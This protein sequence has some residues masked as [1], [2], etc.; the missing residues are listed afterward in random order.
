[1][2]ERPGQPDSNGGK[3]TAAQLDIL[4]R[5]VES[6]P[7]FPALAAA[8]L[9]CTRA[10]QADAGQSTPALQRAIEL[11]CSDAPSVAVLLKTASARGGSPVA[12]IAEA[13]SGLGLAG[14]RHA[15]LTLDI[16]PDAAPSSGLDREAFWRHNQAVAVAARQ[17]AQQIDPPLDADTAFTAGLLHDL[18]KCVLDVLLPKSFRRAIELSAQNGTD[19]CE[20]ERQVIGLDHAVVGRRLAQQWRLPR[21]VAEAAW[22]HHQP[23]TVLPAAA[24]NV[25]LILAVQLADGLA[26]QAKVGDSGNAGPVALS[27]AQALDLDEADLQSVRDGLAQAVQRSAGEIDFEAPAAAQHYYRALKAAAAEMSDRNATLEAQEA[28]LAAQARA[29]EH[30][31][32]FVASLGDPSTT[33]DVMVGIAQVLARAG[34]IVPSADQPVVGYVVGQGDEQGQAVRL[35]GTH[36]HAW[37]SLGSHGQA[38]S[39]PDIPLTAS[40][41]DIAAH[42]DA[43]AQALGPWLDFATYRH[44]A[45]VCAGQWLGGVFLPPS[46]NKAP[47]TTE[48]PFSKAPCTAGGSFREF[49]GSAG[50]FTEASQASAVSDNVLEALAGAMAMALTIVQGRCRA[51]LLSE[52]LA[53]ASQVLA[54]TQEALTEARTVGAVGQMAAGAAHELNNP[55]AVISGRAQLMSERAKT[56]EERKV[57]QLMVTQAHRISDILSDLMEFAAPP[58]PQKTAFDVAQLL[59]EAAEAFSSSAH[60]QAAAA[61]V[62]IQVQADC[63]Q[64][65]ADR[66]QV[67]AVIVELMNNAATAA[68]GPPRLTLGTHEDQARD[69]VVISLADEGPGMDDQTLAAAFTPFFSLQRSGRRRGLGL[70]RARRQIES[71]GGRIWLTSQAGAGTCVYVQLPRPAGH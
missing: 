28:P 65:W 7:T 32:N 69:A 58:P 51:V 49:P 5:R 24:G 21:E 46:G 34:G 48:E 25:R 2:A 30:L 70:P 16:F 52:Q 38:V 50:G 29:F 61:R 4:L 63:G 47:G 54:A 10:E 53:G 64:A 71:N 39:W 1:M 59:G 57:W 60:P 27:Q 11:A 6:L 9:E 67:K 45:L 40:A 68:T 13:G 56:P 17:I 37:Q 55:L 22:L 12:S 35:D 41:A 20:C 14:M 15:A 31:R 62:D 33:N 19:L 43:D 8:L 23:A 66:E 44:V 3:L 36:Q 18:G 26:R 42:L